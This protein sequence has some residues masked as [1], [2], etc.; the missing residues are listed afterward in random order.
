MTEKLFIDEQAV[1]EMTRHIFPKH[2]AKKLAKAAIEHFIEENH[3]NP[4]ADVNMKTIK[5]FIY[6]LIDKKGYN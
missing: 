4:D 1:E 5:N 6:Y 3:M 2:H